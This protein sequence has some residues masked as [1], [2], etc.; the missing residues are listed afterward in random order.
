MYDRQEMDAEA[1]PLDAQGRDPNAAIYAGIGAGIC[2]GAGAITRL[3]LYLKE[4]K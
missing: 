4:V 1:T 3:L 2:A